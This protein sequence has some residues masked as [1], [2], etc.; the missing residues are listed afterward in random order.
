VATERACVWTLGG[1]LDRDQF[2]LLLR[3]SEQVLRPLA[4][5]DGMVSF[6]MPA[7]ILAGRKS[8]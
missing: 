5:A 2:D 6:D 4:G 1:I 3:E 7:L 8:A